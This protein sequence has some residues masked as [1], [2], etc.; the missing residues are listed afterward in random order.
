M[1]KRALITGITG[2]DGSYLS[3]LLLEKGYEVHGIVRR[4]S[5]HYFQNIAHIQNKLNLYYS[6][7]ENEHHLCSLLYKIQPDEVYNLAAQSDV[8]ISFEMPEYTGNIT[9]LGTCRV[10][11]AIRNF[12]P[13]SRYYQA[14]TSELFGITPPPQNENSLMMPASPYAAA[15]LYAHHMTRIYRQAYGLFACCGILFNHESPRRGPILS[16]ER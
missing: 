5:G 13:K 8:G 7:L 10:L 11:E 16:Q 14:S 15:K 3:E 6:D 12:S 2:Q 1:A 4:T 9:G